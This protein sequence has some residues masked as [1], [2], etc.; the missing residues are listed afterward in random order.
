[1]ISK[2]VADAADSLIFWWKDQSV[3]FP[4]LQL[5]YSWPS[6][7]TLDKLVFF[8]RQ[9][10][11]S[12]EERQSFLRSVSSYLGCFAYPFW[13]VLSK[14]I[15][16]VVDLQIV[17][18]DVT[19]SLVTHESVTNSSNPGQEFL[20]I[21][22]SETL[23]RIIRADITELQVLP[24]FRRHD[25]S[26]Q[27]N[28][29]SVLFIGVLTGLSP[30]CKGAMASRPLSESHATT[31]VMVKMLA[32][33]SAEYYQKV[34]SEEKS[35]QVAE[36]YLNEM[37]FP[38]LEMNEG[39][40]AQNAVTGILKFADY[41]GLSDEKLTQLALNLALSPDEI[42]C[43]AGLA[44]YGAIAKG[45]I[46]PRLLTITSGLYPLTIPLRKTMTHARELRYGE[47]DWLYAERDLTNR[48]IA[49]TEREMWLGFLPKLILPREYFGDA[50]VRKVIM[51]FAE[52][53]FPQGV[54]AFNH[55]AGQRKED[56]AMR[57]QKGAIAL[58]GN[59]LEKAEEEYKFFS[60]GSHSVDILAQ[61]IFL[62][63]FC[64]AN[65]RYAD[66]LS[67][68]RKVE[69]TVSERD[70]MTQKD[71]YGRIGT[72]LMYLQRYS[73][74]FTHFRE[75]DPEGETT[76]SA[77]GQVLAARKLQK[78]FR[79]EEALQQLRALWPTSQSVLAALFMEV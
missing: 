79:P 20:K 4:C 50:A 48:D 34:F 8:L 57:L 10:P 5:D 70:V 69:K 3:N 37:I 47:E 56:E 9:S 61:A 17:A 46:D 63:D 64:A 65:H 31:D 77:L 67:F 43:Y 21:N 30:Y 7:G 42:F 29:L 62:A 14:E 51:H 73:E 60:R 28:L 36:L 49:C 35:G 40:L 44:I 59:N 55:L 27:S 18:N 23:S 6:I 2:E 58:L 72:L 66:A 12:G 13:E 32:K 16:A 41:C 15:N 75:T 26:L 25:I 74:A 45:P 24:N 52:I 33:S 19:L 39:S 76:A 38:P 78:P 71:Y 1:M 54:K 68:L 11:H 22:I 53:D